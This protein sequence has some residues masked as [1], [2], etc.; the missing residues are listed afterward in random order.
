MLISLAVLFY[1]DGNA[2]HTHMK[3]GNSINVTNVLI[4]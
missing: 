2:M 3:Y 4:T 1:D